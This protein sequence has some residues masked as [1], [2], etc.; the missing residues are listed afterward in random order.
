MF[1]TQ[2]LLLAAASTVAFAASASA[3]AEIHSAQTQTYT[4]EA[5]A[6]QS[7]LDAWARQ[8]KRHI[9]Y[10]IEDVRGLR[11]PGVKGRYSEFEALSAIL[12][13]SGLALHRDPS[14]AVAV[15]RDTAATG[16]G[17]TALA[18]SAPQVTPATDP[19]AD[20]D[21]SE[22]QDI[23]VTA[24][25]TQERAQ[26]VPVA[27][28]AFTQDTIREKGINTATDLQNFTP[29]LTVLGD[30]ARNQ[31][32]FTIRGM[33]GTGGV[34]TGS[35]PGVVAYFAEVPS[36]VSGPGNFYDLASL[37]VLKGP[38]GTLFGRNTTGGAVLLEPAR[39]KMN[40]VEGYVDGII[41]SLAR[42]SG[43]AA[44]NIP[45]VDDRL[46]IRVAGQF[47]K[48][49]GYVTDA[50]TGR[51]YLNRN[52]YS[53]RVGVQFN[54]TD[55]ISSYTAAS[56]IH[57]DEHGGGSIL[58]SVRPGSPYA[59][60]L[61]PYLAQQQAWG[62]RKTAL[63]TPTFE[64]ARNFL[65]LNN[66]EWRATDTLTIKNIVSYGRSQSTSATDR[67][68]TPLPIAD[69]L[70]AFPGG[71]NNNLRTI[72]EELQVRY[73]NGTFR[74][75]AGGFYLDQ[76]SI[77][78]LTFLTRNP[79]QAGGILGGGP[80]I[81][82]PI[83][84]TLLG[85]N[86]P[87][88]PALGV[89]PDASVKGRSK[90]VYAQ[91]QY[92]FTPTLTATAGFRWTWDTFGGDITSYQD[93][94]SYQVFN[95]LA[96]L[97][98][99]TPAQAA[100]VIG[101]NAN[102]CTYDAFKAVAAGGFPTL[103]YPNCTKP[104]FNGKSD[105]PTWQIGLDWQADP[106]TLLYAVS[107]RGYKSGAN[108]P[109]VTLFLG[110]SYPLAAVKP[111]KVTDAEI[112][113]KRDW[114][115]GGMKARTNVSAFYTWFNDI[116]VIQRAAIAGSDILANA[117]KA[118]V[119]GLEFEGLLVPNKWLTL[120]ATYSYNDAKFLTYTTIPIPA[121]PSALTAA[122]PARDLKGVPFSFVPR[123]KFSLDGR[124]GLPIPA[125]EGDMGLR[126]TW[127]W[128]S[129][130]R[131]APDAQPFDTIPAYGLLNLR[132]EWNNM[133]GAPLDFAVYGTNV[134]NK[135]YRITANTGYNNSGFNNSIYGEP[136][137]YGVELRYRF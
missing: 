105:G 44:L 59:S 10:R 120:G 53:L 61:A 84:Q 56:Y 102:L 9:V 98:L 6:M 27:I 107:R 113:I 89:Q 13:G 133:R 132:F 126:A 76:K 36:S 97:G 136:A 30:V 108:N 109:I 8:S 118:R 114:R 55:T 88:L 20:G 1:R 131:V 45:V 72:T 63:S 115:L 34:G 75:Q 5:G 125:S 106:D 46:A 32:T 128:Q 11:S 29:S 94:S 117:Q 91:A 60:V 70:G 73:D 79:L 12:A 14:G 58:L 50:I 62:V 51:D 95:Q 41:G 93:A 28:T 78:A 49:D 38:Q 137:Q 86:G 33:G 110:D 68:S 4:I 64:K 90:A 77:G 57:V 15:S 124:I 39:P 101:L 129:S 3:Q 104:T 40:T 47:D 112:G 24:R 7:A 80:I 43:Q 111:E 85:V 23:I 25:R 96:A 21:S 22:I 123:H 82:P 71:W 99:V 103:H 121:I 69:L 87:L 42:K 66:T 17:G 134:L 100:Q 92:K 74:V 54:P 18:A 83:A 65:V 19:S 35:G 116:Q 122:Q 48:R 130:Q 31:E 119:V 127:S 37:Q 135:E 52:N 16:N 67:D 81:L 26:K 2:A